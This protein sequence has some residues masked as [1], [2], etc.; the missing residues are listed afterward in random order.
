M[1]L[2]IDETRP[3]SFHFAIGQKLASLREEGILILGSGNIV[4]N[5]HTYAWGRHMP[6]PY[7]WRCR[8]E[9]TAKELIQ[10]GDY[11]SLVNYE[12]SGRMRCSQFRRLTI[13]CPCCT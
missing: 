5:L 1:Q 4:H 3:A 12:T 11:K 2:S 10:S 9:T 8:F 13:T 7:D 6:E